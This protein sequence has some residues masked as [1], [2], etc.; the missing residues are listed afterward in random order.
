M[1]GSETQ[2][3][4]FFLQMEHIGSK[5]TTV[6]PRA[7]NRFILGSDLSSSNHSS[8]LENNPT[9]SPILRHVYR[10]VFKNTSTSPQFSHIRNRNY[11][12]SGSPQ[13][14]FPVVRSRRHSG[15]R[16]VI[17][18]DKE[19]TQVDNGDQAI[20]DSQQEGSILTQHGTGSLPE[21]TMSTD[22]RKLVKKRKHS[23]K[24]VTSKRYAEQFIKNT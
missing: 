19:S 12:L 9:R 11:L 2:S 14:H 23:Q 10:P 22:I 8:E 21:N 1:V 5:L 13:Q 16:R 18:F 15:S 17:D 7:Q 3:F 24:E 4:V 6:A 20:S